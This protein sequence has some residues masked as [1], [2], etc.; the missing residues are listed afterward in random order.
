MK[1]K[2]G[3]EIK[4]NDM[5]LQA[6]IVSEFVNMGYSIVSEECYRKYYLFGEMNYRTVVKK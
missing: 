4:T 1:K 3:I 6:S 5:L 2:N